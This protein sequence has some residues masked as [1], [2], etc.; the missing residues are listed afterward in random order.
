MEVHQ[1]FGQ[2]YIT[3]AACQLMFKDIFDKP[4]GRIHGVASLTG[5]SV[6]GHSITGQSVTGQSVTG[7]SVTGWDRCLL[8]G[9]LYS[10]MGPW[11]RQCTG[12]L[13]LFT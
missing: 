7:Q 2:D 3:V 8:Q 11:A 1:S 4:H 13:Q 9:P 12:L 6:T 10:T 5:Q